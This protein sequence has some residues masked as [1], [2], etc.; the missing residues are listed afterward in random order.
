MAQVLGLAAAAL[1]NRAALRL[2]VSRCWRR[3]IHARRPPPP[4]R[5]A[6]GLQGPLVPVGPPVSVAAFEPKPLAPRRC[7]CQPTCA[8]AVVCLVLVAYASLILVMPNAGEI[9]SR[10]RDCHSPCN[11]VRPLCCMHNDPAVL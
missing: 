8:L 4:G 5:A 7:C 11:H 6:G 2:L 9:Y 1:A 10:G 3:L